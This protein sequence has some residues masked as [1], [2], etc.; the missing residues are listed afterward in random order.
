MRLPSRLGKAARVSCGVVPRERVVGRPVVVAASPRGRSCHRLVLPPRFLRPPAPY[1]LDPFLLPPPRLHRASA[2]SCRPPRGALHSPT[3]GAL[4]EAY[5]RGS[6]VIGRQ[7]AGL[8]SGWRRARACDSRAV[9]GWRALLPHRCSSGAPLAPP[10]GWSCSSTGAARGGG[11]K[12][13][14]ARRQSV[15]VS[16]VPRARRR[17]RGVARPTT[18]RGGAQSH[19]ARQRSGVLLSAPVVVALRPTAALP[20]AVCRLFVAPPPPPA[21]CLP[22]CRVVVLRRAAAGQAVM[23][24]WLAM[25]A[26]RVALLA[27]VVRSLEARGA[28]AAR[29]PQGDARRASSSPPMRRTVGTRVAL[30][31]ISPRNDDE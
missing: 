13:P 5:V 27:D 4:D 3:G 16:N 24:V 26:S 10:R 7:D 18:P 11:E 9:S 31:G 15:L 22:A 30:E 23:V 20:A 28:T 14:L 19:S 29:A 21:R 6:G 12:E 17:G 1:L 2:A 8:V 25:L